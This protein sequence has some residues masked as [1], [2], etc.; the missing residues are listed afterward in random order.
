MT[1]EDTMQAADASTPGHEQATHVE[2]ETLCFEA[3]RTQ[4]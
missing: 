4:F 2:F 1:T 3:M